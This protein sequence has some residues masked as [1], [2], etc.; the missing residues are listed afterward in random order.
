MPDL[1]TITVTAGQ[2]TKLLNLF[3]DVPTY[4]KWL[5]AAVRQEA[6]R[7]QTVILNEAANQSVQADLAAFEAQIPPA[8]PAE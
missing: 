7:R 3:G 5:K 4:Q 8:D 2:A 6:L 1:P